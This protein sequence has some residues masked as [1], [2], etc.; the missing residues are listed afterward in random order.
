MLKV[1]V[2]SRVS[3]EEKHRTRNTL[4]ESSWVG[5]L[6]S[7]DAAGFK[8]YLDLSKKMLHLLT[9]FLTGH[10]LM[11]MSLAEDDADKLGRR[12]KLQITWLAWPSL[13][14]AKKCFKQG[15]CRG[16]EVTPLEPSQIL[17]FMK[18]LELKGE[19]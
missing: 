2:Q 10:Y 9:G 11:R 16:G 7:F 8:G 15:T 19:L 18:T 17:E 6:K 4:A 14:N 1:N 5:S 12:K 13:A 3:G